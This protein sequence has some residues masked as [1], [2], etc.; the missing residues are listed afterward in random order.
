MVFC[1]IFNFI[2]VF[3]G[4]T[5]WYNVY[6]TCIYYLDI[7]ASLL[8]IVIAFVLIYG[9]QKRSKSALVIYRI[10]ACFMVIPIMLRAIFV[11]LRMQAI[12]EDSSGK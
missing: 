9:T 12:S 6:Y 10:S 1:Y 8:G 11:I 3:V 4:K 5:T 2:R 7:V